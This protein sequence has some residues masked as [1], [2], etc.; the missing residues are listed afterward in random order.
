LV[1]VKPGFLATLT[2]W[3]YTGFDLGLTLLAL[4]SV[5][6]LLLR[7]GKPV[8]PEAGMGQPRPATT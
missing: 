2:R 6:T 5:I 8:A 3:A 4:V 7:L 1:L